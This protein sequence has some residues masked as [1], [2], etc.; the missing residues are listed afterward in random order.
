[1]KWNE[2][3]AE[4]SHDERETPVIHTNIERT[5]IIKSEV[6][7]ALAVLNIKKATWPER[8]VTDAGSLRWFLRGQNYRH[9]EIY[10]RS[11]IL[12]HRNFYFYITD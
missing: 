11:D 9:N 6:E 2:Y 3:I 4:F 8:I 5:V 7:S 10:N 12:E 1:M